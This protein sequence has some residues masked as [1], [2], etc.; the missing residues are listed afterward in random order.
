MKPAKVTV[1]HFKF[2][3]AVRLPFLT[4]HQINGET[5]DGERSFFVFKPKKAPYGSWPAF[6]SVPVCV[7]RID[8][9]QAQAPSTAERNRQ[10]DHRIHM[11]RYRKM[12]DEMLWEGENELQCSET[13]C[14]LLTSVSCHSIRRRFGAR[15]SLPL[16]PECR[17]ER[18]TAWEKR[19]VHTAELFPLLKR[20]CHSSLSLS[21]PLSLY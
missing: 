9:W 6:S 21:L 2:H 4:A 1:T 19:Q 5:K 8:G 16:S 11:Y 7:S 20:S 12:K 15:K 13:E 3:Y 18:P 14:G 17:K 10:R